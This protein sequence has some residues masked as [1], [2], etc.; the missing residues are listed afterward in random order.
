MKPDCMCGSTDT[1]CPKSTPAVQPADQPR[2]VATPDV[3]L[4]CFHCHDAEAPE[5]RLRRKGGKYIALCFKSGEGCWE[6]AVPPTC[7]YTDHQGVECTF[8]AEWEIAYGADMLMRAHRCVMHIG[9]A[10]SDVGEHRIF[11]I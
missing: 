7:D 9:P 11:A 5:Y 10:L 1:H 4:Y 6:R 3:L 2:I 8:V